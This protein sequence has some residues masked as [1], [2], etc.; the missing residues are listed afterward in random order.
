MIQGL[1]R[2]ERLDVGTMN[3]IAFEH[4]AQLPTLRSLRI[5]G[6]QAFIR[7]GPPVSHSFLTLRELAIH[8]SPDFLAR[9]IAVNDTWSLVSLTASMASSPT[10]TQTVHLFTL[11][12]ER[13]NATCLTRLAIAST[14]PGPWSR[15]IPVQTLRSLLGF[16]NLCEIGLQLNF[17]L[18]DFAVEGLAQAWPRVKN[19][20]VEAGALYR[21]PP[22][23]VTLRGL[24]SLA[25]YCR[26]L[27]RLSMRFDASEVP[28]DGPPSESDTGFSLFIFGVEDSVLAQPVAVAAYIFATFPNVRDMRPAVLEFEEDEDDV[29]HLI[30]RVVLL[31]DLWEEVLALHP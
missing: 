15:A 29:D 11:L 27:R 25:R 12:A 6:R 1:P 3:Q 14:D 17:D 5:H 31:Q 10:L 9:F 13:C 18:D 30:Q 22:S 16:A 28:A 21:R 7:S 24:R 8:V 20:A 4:L 23:R 19:L 26:D 2:L